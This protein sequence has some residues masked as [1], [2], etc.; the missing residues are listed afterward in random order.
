MVFV[1]HKEDFQDIL[2]ESIHSLS[3]QQAYRLMSRILPAN[4]SRSTSQQ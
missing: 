3:D 2:Q 1:P 4:E